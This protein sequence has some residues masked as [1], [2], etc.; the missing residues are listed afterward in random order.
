[1]FFLK[2]SYLG[3]GMAMGFAV[4]AA[5][6]TAALMACP[7]GRC[8]ARRVMRQGQRTVKKIAPQLRKYR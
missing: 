5:A 2:K 7:Q 6:V 3:T 8:M 1:M 4:G